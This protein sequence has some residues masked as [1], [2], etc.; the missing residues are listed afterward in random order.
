MSTRSPMDC[1]VMDVLPLIGRSA[2]VARLLS[3][4]EETK[5]GVGNTL[6]VSGEGGV[7]KTR[8][9]MEVAERSMADGWT[10]LIGRSHAV[11]TGIPY[12]LFSD[13]F[14]P[15]LQS[16]DPAALNVLTRGNS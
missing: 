7:G 1:Y 4:L 9:L 2:E 8:L 3:L 16:L 6:F 10:V 14:L 15:L 5:E 12:A 11:E 13:A